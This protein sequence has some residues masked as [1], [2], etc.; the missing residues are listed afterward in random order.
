VGKASAIAALPVPVL[1]VAAFAYI[2]IKMV[3]NLA[4][5]Y[6]I[7]VRTRDKLILASAVSAILSKLI[8]EAVISL[9]SDS[10]LSKFLGEALVKASISG[11]ITRVTGEVYNNH[12]LNGGNLNDITPATFIEYFQIQLA[13]ERLS[14][15]KISSNIIDGAL[16]KIGID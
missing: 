4:K 5:L 16:Q 7:E 14:I 15:G 9:T 13:S 1:D 6:H 8:S 11:F 12:F 3:E 2:Q 10:S